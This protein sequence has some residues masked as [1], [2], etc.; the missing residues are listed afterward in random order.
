MWLPLIYPRTVDLARYIYRTRARSAVSA[1]WSPR[2]VTELPT[3]LTKPLG[4]KSVP[5]MQRLGKKNA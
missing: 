2:R 3:P 4:R 5:D 1:Y